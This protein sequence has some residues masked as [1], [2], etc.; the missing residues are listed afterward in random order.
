MPAIAMQ[1]R[2]ALL[3]VAPILPAAGG[4][5]L[6][7][8]AGV[9][10]DALAADFTVTLLVVPIAGATGGRGSRFVAERTRRVVVVDLDGKLDPLWSQLSRIADAGARAAA[11]AAYRHPAPCR[12]AGAAY[13]ADA[14]AALGGERFDAVHVMRSYMAPYAEP[15]LVPAG[16]GPRPW[17]SLDLDDDEAATHIRLAA[18]A[19]RAGDAGE[20]RAAAAEAARY[21]RHEAAWLPRFDLLT[22][23][24]DAHARQVAAAY[25]GCRA[26][27]VPNTVA[28]PTSARPRPAPC[29][30]ILFVGNLSY[31]PNVDGICGFVR[32][33]YP[34]LRERYGDGVALRIA[35]G[36]PAPEVAR[37]AAHPGIVVV[38]NPPD[39]RPHY[40]WADLAVVP[41][42][43]GGC[44]RIK[45][46]E[47]F[48][49]GVPVVATTIGAEGIA[50]EHGAHLVIADAPEGFAAA[51]CRVLSDPALAARLA[52]AARQLVEAAYSH[53]CGVRLIRA[54]FAPAAGG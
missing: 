9:F 12:Y 8:R 46:L 31:R 20:A 51:C 38:A 26:A 14:A 25:P 40:E 23:C 18:L 19:E 35:G 53:P 43:A 41:I 15:F 49:H 13:R 45:L 7:M 34:R 48:A 22:T 50:A 36:A 11:A 30:R 32:D 42:A 47:A 2:P 1:R 4:N 10:L 16:G 54:A 33:V 5:G 29:G 44:T 6:A 39:L 28:L 37:L 27:V 3:F 52:A 21:V 24:T 17:A